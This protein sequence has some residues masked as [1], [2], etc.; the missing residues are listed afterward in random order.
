MSAVNLTEALALPGWMS[1]DELAF[2]AER[3]QTCQRVTVYAE[4]TM[5]MLYVGR[6]GAP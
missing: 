3:A 2:L 5:L 4:M 1:E 6:V